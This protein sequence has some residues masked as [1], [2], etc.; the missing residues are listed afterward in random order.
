[1]PKYKRSY[2]ALPIFA[3]L[4]LILF[5]FQN[6]APVNE[7]AINPVPPLDAPVGIVDNFNSAKVSFVN[8]N[9]LIQQ[10]SMGFAL[11][12][13]CVGSPQGQLVEYQVIELGGLP[14]VVDAGVVECVGGGFE[15]IL[16]Q[17]HFSSC[18]SKWQ[19]RAVRQGI[20]D[21]VAEAILNPD[22]ITGG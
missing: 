18:G 9:W 19:I 7:M 5:K 17:V 8:N 10:D 14:K 22:C 15:L 13:L 1:M 12:G 4:S 11:Q 3:L 20:S 16:S 6:C 2:K 21:Q